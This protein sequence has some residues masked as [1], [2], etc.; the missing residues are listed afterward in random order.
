MI[1]RVLEEGQYEIDDANAEVVERL[2]TVLGDALRSGDEDTFSATLAAVL[3]EVRSTGRR[4][5]DTTIVPSDLA[6]PHPGATLA[7]VQ[8]L[9]ADDA[10]SAIDRR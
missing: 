3:A 5:E 9:L 6:L 1:V 7:E 10:E 4:V 2:D 8:A